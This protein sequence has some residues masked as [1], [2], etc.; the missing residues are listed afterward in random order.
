[1]WLGAARCAANLPIS[2]ARTCVIFDCQQP[3]QIRGAFVCRG[4]GPASSGGKMV[5]F[6]TGTIKVRL[7]H[8]YIVAW[9]ML[10][11]P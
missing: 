9:G 3:L 4:G 6:K 10:A 7:A 2:A 8:I 5:P 1:M 11:Y